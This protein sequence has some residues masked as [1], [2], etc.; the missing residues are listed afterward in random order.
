MIFHVLY[1]AYL[2]SMQLPADLKDESG[3]HDCSIEK[4]LAFMVDSQSWASQHQFWL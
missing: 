4:D 3:E 2:A 1:K